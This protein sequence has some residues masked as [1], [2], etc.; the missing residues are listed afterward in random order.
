MGRFAGGSVR[1]LGGTHCGLRLRR[2]DSALVGRVVATENGLAA[3]FSAPASRLGVVE[4]LVRRSTERRHHGFASS[5]RRGRGGR[6]RKVA[7]RP[8]RK[9]ASLPHRGISS[10]PYPSWLPA[11]Q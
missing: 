1:L 10:R 2:V 3:V 4:P 9:Q 11:T 6:P 5:L 8:T 7:E